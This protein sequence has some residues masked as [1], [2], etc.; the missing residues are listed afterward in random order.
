MVLLLPL[1]PLAGGWSA[2][3]N[4]VVLE[5]SRIG[6]AAAHGR[7]RAVEGEVGAVE[8]KEEV[9]ILDAGRSAGEA[10]DCTSV[11]VS[12]I[13]LADTF[14]MVDRW[15]PC[16]SGVVVVSGVGRLSSLVSSRVFDF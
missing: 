12:R 16:G 6:R 8:E 7:R 2:L 15:S 9:E 5:N 3:R 13:E 14:S 10:I 4:A 1:L 11:R